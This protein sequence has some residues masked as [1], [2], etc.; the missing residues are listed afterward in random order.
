MPA[1]NR[2]A[3]ASVNQLGVL[4]EAEDDGIEAPR[5][6][7]VSSDY[8]LLSL[9]HPHLLPGTVTLS[10]FVLVNNKAFN[11]KYPAIVKGA[12]LDARRDRD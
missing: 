6:N 5:A 12:G 3:S 4:V 1:R 10:R 2:C 9:V 8:E 11:R 7:R